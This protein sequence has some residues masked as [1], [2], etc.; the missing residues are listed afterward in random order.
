MKV[1]RSRSSASL[2]AAPLPPSSVWGWDVDGAAPGFEAPPLSP[3]SGVPDCMPCQVGAGS[4][5]RPSLSP[6]VTLSTTTSTTT[7][8]P[9]A[10][11][12]SARLLPTF[13]RHLFFTSALAAAQI[14]LPLGLLRFGLFTGDPQRVQKTA[15]SGSRAPHF[16]Q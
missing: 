10:Q 13:L 11:A 4:L 2:S 12:M 5:P 14:S 6:N 16:V 3:S 1:P 8:R 7:T 9:I 15:P